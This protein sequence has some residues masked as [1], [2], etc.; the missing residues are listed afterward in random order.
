MRKGIGAGGTGIRN[1]IEHHPNAYAKPILVLHF[2][3]APTVT[4]PY[5]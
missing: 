4:F 1:L 2:A 3:R 5:Y